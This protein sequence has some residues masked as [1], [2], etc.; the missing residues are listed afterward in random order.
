M[1][2]DTSHSLALEDLECGGGRFAEDT[3]PSSENV[4][5]KRN[6]SSVKS[7]FKRLVT[8]FSLG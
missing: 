3:F 5:V 7:S 4:K 1:R 2:P 8:G 6:G